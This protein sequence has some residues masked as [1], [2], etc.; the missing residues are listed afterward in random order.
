MEKLTS[1][2]YWDTRYEE[3][4]HTEWLLDAEQLGRRVE[5]AAS[6]WGKQARILHLGCGTSLLPEYLFQQGYRNVSNIDNSPVCISTMSQR[7]PH[8]SFELMNLNNLQ[9][10]ETTFD[11]VVEKSTLDTLISD[12]SVERGFLVQTGLRE[13]RRVLKPGGVVLSVSLLSANKHS[14][15]L[16]PL[17]GRAEHELIRGGEDQVDCNV[18]TVYLDEGNRDDGGVQSLVTQKSLEDQNQAAFSDEE[19]LNDRG[20]EDYDC[21]GLSEEYKDLVRSMIS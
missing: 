12:C 9:Y 8:L 1:T 21:D 20:E 2:Q 13:L 19:D 7:F 4:E 5:D 18:A 6:K 10:E 17:G 15:I 16:S 11:I 3:E 14:S